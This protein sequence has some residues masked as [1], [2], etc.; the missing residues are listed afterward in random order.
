MDCDEPIAEVRLD[1]VPWTRVCIDCKQ[2]Q[3]NRKK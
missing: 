1:A 3:D 2:G